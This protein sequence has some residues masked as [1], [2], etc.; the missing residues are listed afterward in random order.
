MEGIKAGVRNPAWLMVFIF[1]ACT[2]WAGDQM[3]W[4]LVAP[5]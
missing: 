3:A 1:S 4:K 2:K 5:E